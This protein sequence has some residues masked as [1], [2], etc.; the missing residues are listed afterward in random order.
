MRR[1]ILLNIL[2]NLPATRG[3]KKRRDGKINIPEVL[4]QYNKVAKECDRERRGKKEIHIGMKRGAGG[5]N[6]AAAV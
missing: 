5:G 1:C 3:I 6:I 4:L 2:A